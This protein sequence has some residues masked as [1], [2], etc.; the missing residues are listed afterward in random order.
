M[1]TLF[2]TLLMKL[3]RWG[4]LDLIVFI[5][6]LGILYAIFRR[7]KILGT[8]PIINGIVSFGIAFMVIVFPLLTGVGVVI[9]LSK[10]FT[11]ALIF[12]LVFLFAF[13]ISSLFYP[14]LLEWLPKVFTSRNTLWSMVG[15]AITLFITS[16]LVSIMYK[17]VSAGNVQ[18]GGIT[19]QV[20]EGTKSHSTSSDVYI[21]VTGLIIFIVLML[22]ASSMGRSK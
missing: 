11:Q 17:S 22:I 3:I 19:P 5:I 1:Q 2:S 20:S 6:S 4:F 15:L 14:N 21:I 12:I 8:S 9:P 10:F 13:V 16:G 7:S 18:T